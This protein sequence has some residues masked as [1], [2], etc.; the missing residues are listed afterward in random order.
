MILPKNVLIRTHILQDKCSI[1]KK[2]YLNLQER[3]LE[4]ND[5]DEEEEVMAVMCHNVKLTLA[6]KWTERLMNSSS[7]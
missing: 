3:D 4:E 5:N 7:S 1:M 6:S 2:E